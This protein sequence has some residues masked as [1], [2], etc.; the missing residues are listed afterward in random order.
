MVDAGGPA[1]A[2][3][4]TAV[5]PPDHA[6]E[7]RHVHKRYATRRS[8]RA[9]PRVVD[10]LHDVSLAVARG[11]FVSIVGPSGCGKSTLMELIAGLE[12]V[13][14]GRITFDGVPVTGPPP[15]VVMVFQQPLLLPWRTVTQN[16]LISQD[17]NRR[18]PEQEA[19]ARA[20]DMLAMLGLAEFADR[21]PG[22]LS[23]GMQ[24]RVG[25]GRALMH[26]PEILLMDEPFGALDA[27]TRDQMGMDLLN[28][29]ER[30]RKTVLFVTHSIPESVLLSDRVVVM[31]PRPGRIAD[32][33]DVDLPR[34]RGL[35]NIN[36]PEFGAIVRRIRVL[37]NSE[38]SAH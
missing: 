25:I 32:I 6:V 28:I 20:R 9:A 30:D 24:Q 29:W 3:A 11:E 26:D 12:P 16:L 8:R 18:L 37:L 31:T 10:A 4:D 22:E 38:H 21:Y 2:A 19:R 27:M 1:G 23:G 15:G 5:A 13:S 35:E 36:T 17:I 33:V 7:L 14:S 34:P